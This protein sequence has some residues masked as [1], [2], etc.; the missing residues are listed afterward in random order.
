LAAPRAA[1]APS[2]WPRSL[3]PA[4]FAP[5]KPP[6]RNPNAGS[7]S[8]S[9]APCPQSAARHLPHHGRRT[10]APRN[11]RPQTDAGQAGRRTIPK[12]L[13]DGQPIAQLQNA[14][15]LRCL[16][17]QHSFRR[18]GASGQEITEILPHIGGIADEIC[19]VRSMIT[20]K[21]TTTRRRPS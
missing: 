8:P 11:L 1:S 17:P 18:W 3:I 15:E 2:P 4:C 12:S 14:K 6:P 9:P 19:I 10:V 16:G 5:P 13:T 20:D 7:V 21:S